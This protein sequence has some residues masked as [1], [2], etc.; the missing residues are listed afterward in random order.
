VAIRFPEYQAY[1]RRKILHFGHGILAAGTPLALLNMVSPAAAETGTQP[2]W[3]F[4]TKCHLMFYNGYALLKNQPTYT[5]HCPAGGAHLPQGWEFFLD[6]DSAKKTTPPPDPSRQFDWRYC[7]KCF[8]LFWDGDTSVTDREGHPLKKGVCPAGG[9]HHEQ[10]YMFGLYYTS[11]TRLSPRNPPGAY[12]SDWRFCDKCYGLFYN[13]AGYGNGRCAGP[14][15]QHVAAGYDFWIAFKDNP[16][17]NGPPPVAPPAPLTADQQALLDAH[18]AYRAKHCVQPLTWSPQAAAAA[19]QWA[20]GCH[21]NA[22]GTFAHEDQHTYGENLAWGTGLSAHGAVDLWYAEIKS[23][24]FAAPVYTTSPEVGH[25]TQLVWK[26]TTQVG[27]AMKVCNGQNLWVCR[28]LPPGNWNV[29]PNA[30]LTAQQAQQ[31]LIANVLR[32]CH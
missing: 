14:T 24:N 18:N 20:N 32:P 2:E 29:V 9:K 7:D 11:N 28:Y 1:S 23:Y 19:A 16:P 12:Q 4:C 31:N 10:G 8:S 30:N 3:R 6:Y 22:N 15:G 21:Q 5:G 26:T 17:K 27:G 25:F 13:G